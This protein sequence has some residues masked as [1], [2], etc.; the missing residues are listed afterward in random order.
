MGQG[1]SRRRLP[2]ASRRWGRGEGAEQLWFH[3]RRGE[4]RRDC[5]SE[6]RAEAPLGA[7]VPPDKPFQTCQSSCEP[8]SASQITSSP[9]ETCFA[10]SLFHHLITFLL[11]IALWSMTQL[12]GGDAVWCE[13]EACV[14]G[15]MKGCFAVLMLEPGVPRMTKAS[16]SH[17]DLFWGHP[18]LSGCREISW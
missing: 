3:R 15:R 12:Q 1:L 18:A 7:V 8:S 16:Q 14:L 9:P 10:S 11:L 2:G 17:P 13:P 4:V 5:S 6:G